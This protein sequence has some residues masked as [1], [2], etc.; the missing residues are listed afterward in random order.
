MKPQPGKNNF[1][2]ADKKKFHRGKNKLFY[3]TWPLRLKAERNHTQP[4]LFKKSVFI[5]ANRQMRTILDILKNLVVVQF[6]PR[7]HS[8]T[9]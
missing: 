7:R 2:I 5:R 9:A 1:C 8:D 3:L 6:E 4:S